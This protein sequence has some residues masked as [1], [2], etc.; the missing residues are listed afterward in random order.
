MADICGILFPRQEHGVDSS[1]ECPLPIG[2]D[3]PHLA[4][5]TAWEYDVECDCHDCQSEDPHDRCCVFWPVFT[6]KN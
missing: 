3:G 4:G 2:H 6:G 1:A 5:K